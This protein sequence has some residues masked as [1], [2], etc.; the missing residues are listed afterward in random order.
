MGPHG[1]D[2]P[3]HASNRSE[4]PTLAHMLEAGISRWRGTSI[5]KQM[6]PLCWKPRSHCQPVVSDESERYAFCGNGYLNGFGTGWKCERGF[7][8]K[9]G[10]CVSVK[11]PTK[12][13]LIIPGA[14]G[15][16]TGHFEDKTMVVYCHSERVRAPGFIFLHSPP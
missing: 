2:Q 6:S 4:A 13:I 15:V 12:L 11:L 1:R 16:A 5:G 3:R 7:K 9:G 10:D 8:K 14:T